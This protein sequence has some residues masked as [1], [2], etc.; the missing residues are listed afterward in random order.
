MSPKGKDLSAAIRKLGF[1]IAR[2]ARRQQFVVRSDE[3][4]V[5]WFETSDDAAFTFGYV[6]L[7]SCLSWFEFS[8]ELHA[9]KA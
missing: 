6:G 7:I 1:S 9:V 8:V 2:D 3:R 5:G 4:E